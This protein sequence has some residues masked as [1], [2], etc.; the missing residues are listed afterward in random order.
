MLN[1]NF[2]SISVV[3]ILCN[4]QFWDKQIYKTS[5]YNNIVGEVQYQKTKEVEACLV[6]KVH[7]N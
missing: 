4:H 6:L 3:L 5:M 1:L 7:L 2:L